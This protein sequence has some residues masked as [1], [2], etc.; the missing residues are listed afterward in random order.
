MEMAYGD[1]L[2]FVAKISTVGT[3]CIELLWIKFRNESERGIQGTL[4]SLLVNP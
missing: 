1:E 2:E 3:G 4:G